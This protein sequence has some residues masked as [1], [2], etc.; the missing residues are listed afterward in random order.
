MDPS[1][2]G[3]NEI[4]AVWLRPS[5]FS[6]R[7]SLLL[8]LC[9]TSQGVD[10]GRV[11]RLFLDFPDSRRTASQEIAQSLPLRLLFPSRWRWCQW[12]E[13]CDP[14]KDGPEQSSRN[15]HL[16]HLKRDVPCVG[17]DLGTNLDQLL[18]QRCQR[19]VLYALG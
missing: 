12:S 8:A 1:A 4:E 19:P 16:G 7:R 9:E 5:A 13:S 14:A 10:F 17:H 3:A 18:P 2:T 11:A 6:T 15:S